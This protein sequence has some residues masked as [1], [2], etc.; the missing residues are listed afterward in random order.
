MADVRV[1]FE[2]EGDP[3]FVHIPEEWLTSLDEDD[4]R[5]RIIHTLR[6]DAA[7]QK[8]GPAADVLES[9]A[10]ALKDAWRRTKEITA[11]HQ[12]SA[13]QLWDKAQ[14]YEGRAPLT[15]P[16]LGTL[17]AMQYVYAPIEG[18]TRGFIGEPIADLAGAGLDLYTRI[19]GGDPDAIREY[20]ERTGT[21]TPE[22]FI[23]DFTTWG[24]QLVTPGNYARAVKSYL[25][26]NQKVGGPIGVLAGE[27]KPVVTSGP[28]TSASGKHADVP[29]V[30]EAVPEGLGPVEV[31]LTTQGAVPRL[32]VASV[33]DVATEPS[34][35]LKVA[36]ARAN[37]ELKG[38][39][40]FRT[41]ARYLKEGLESG[42]L[43]SGQIPRLLED[44]EM[45]P[46]E[47]AKFMETSVSESGRILN[48]L[49]QASRQMAKDKRYPQELRDEL[50]A[51]AGRMADGKRV[52]TSYLGDLWRKAE[53]IRRGMLVGQ[54][55][56]TMRNI[57]TQFGRLTVG[58]VDDAL[59]AAMRGTTARESMGNLWNSVSADFAAMPVVNRMNGGRKIVDSILEGNPV[60]KE[61]LLNRTVHEV[62]QINKF[63]NGVNKLNTLQERFFRRTAFQARLQKTLKE[64]GMDINTISPKEIPP[65]LME[66]AVQHALEISFAHGGKAFSKGIVRAFHDF[67]F[68]Y[69]VNPFPRFTFANAI[70]FV[71][72]HSP[73]GLATAFK[74]STVAELAAGNSRKFVKTA[75]R[76]LIGTML[77]AKAIEMRNGP[78]AGERFYEY[79][80]SVDP[81][82]GDA[83]TANLLPYAPFTTYLAIAEAMKGGDSTMVPMDWAKAA[84]GLNRISG[85]GLVFID[86][87]RSGTQEI[88]GEKMAKW[89]A[90]YVSSPTVPLRTVKDVEQSITGQDFGRDIKSDRF[91][92]D[93][94]NPTVSNMP[95]LDKFLAERRSPLEVG[96]QRFESVNFFGHKI[97]AGIARQVFGMTIRNKNVIQQEVDRLGMKYTSFMPNT[98]LKELD[99]YVSM[100]M[101][102]SVVAM[103][104]AL[105]KSDKPVIEEFPELK[106]SI[107]GAFDPTKSYKELSDE[108]KEIAL[109][110]AFQFLRSY[111]YSE[112]E[113]LYPELWAASEFGKIGGAE[114]RYL[115]ERFGIDL[116]KPEDVRRLMERLNTQQ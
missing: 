62:D 84:I 27:G 80:T 41:Y 58:I 38:E 74:P 4:L 107:L 90:Q 23:E 12:E 34:L 91:W 3:R 46:V 88:G 9:G 14:S 61:M 22:K 105:M 7:K 28:V 60:T 37:P 72:E 92:I 39:R 30:P 71:Y 49:S 56:T 21:Y 112:A 52:D 68:L 57:E 113:R 79:K 101:A 106:D 36:R 40:L 116:R 8:T 82:T 108:G 89:I 97:P 20:T 32:S 65:E 98:G 11:Y 45:N 75:S 59:Q 25:P 69:T 111:A 17:A 10:D 54:V 33:V 115:K 99:R 44:M 67:P 24:S 47:F 26:I 42:E 53:N 15:A 13:G 2:F 6:A 76:G 73:I 83:R 43:S 77:L 104:P 100:Y 78:N 18:V 55:A 16:L 87:L 64:L 51:I 29:T 110:K 94:L 114:A 1:D 85:T 109:G 50:N 66:D 63:V 103:V 81:E 5:E 86:A 93:I 70:P 95:F 96:R 31:D 102:P 35:L 19:S 48:I